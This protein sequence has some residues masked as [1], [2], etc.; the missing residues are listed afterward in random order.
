MGLLDEAIREHLELKRRRGAD[1]TE[2]A[3][4]QHEA[5]E[6]AYEHARGADDEHAAG[7]APDER[8]SEPPPS[9]E[10]ADDLVGA[11]TAELDMR[12]VLDPSI[13]ADADA[14]ADA[15][16]WEEPGSRAVSGTGEP[17]APEA[18]GEHR[19]GPA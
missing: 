18:A 13:P 8:G 12:T 6:T 2:V 3:R 4:E 17:I 10:G 16:E 1:P 14:D 9:I 7:F 19:L 15:I 11:E 5:L